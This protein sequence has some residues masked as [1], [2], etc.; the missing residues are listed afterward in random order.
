MSTSQK[1]ELLVD[2]DILLYRCG[3]AAEKTKYLVL[4][5]DGGFAEFDNAKD[6]KAD[7]DANITQGE[8]FSGPTLW[9][10]K[11]IQPVEFAFNN[12]NTVLESLVAR[13]DPADVKLY[14]SDD[15][16]FRNQVATT[17]LYKGNR[18][19]NHKPKHYK[20]IKEFLLGKGAIIHPNW[21]ADDAIGVEA[22]QPDGKRRII[23]STDKDLDQI[24]GEHYNWV[25]GELYDVSKRAGDV[26]LFTQLLTGDT[27]DNIPGLPDMGPVKARK[28]LDGAAS[29]KELYD[30]VR[31]A[32]SE[33]DVHHSRNGS[34][35]FAEQAQ[36]VFILRHDAQSWKDYE[37]KINGTS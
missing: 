35:Y 2:G 23:V 13:F 37:A 1:P 32:Y 9:S 20:A 3:F 15:V 17:K 5:D 25:T 24:A 8:P 36:L 19:P 29:R 7:V 26:Y 30:R 33:L 21:E 14:L 31:G 27:T 10:R 12:V 22:S 4:F 16:V 6:A 11:E 28:L 18:D 34:D